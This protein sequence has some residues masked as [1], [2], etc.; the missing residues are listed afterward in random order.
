[1]GSYDADLK[2]TIEEPTKSHRLRVSTPV[3]WNWIVARTGSHESA[4]FG[5]SLFGAGSRRTGRFI[6]QERLGISFHDRLI[7]DDFRYV[8]SRGNRVHRF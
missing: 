5:A 6:D 2:G 1:M 7:H 8:W 3:G 4:R